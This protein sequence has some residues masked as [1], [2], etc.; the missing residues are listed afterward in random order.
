[1]QCPNYHDMG[2]QLYDDISSIG[3]EISLRFKNEP[4]MA[5]KWLLGCNIHVE[6]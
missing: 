6:G 5:F 2:L 4:G 3:G 1:M